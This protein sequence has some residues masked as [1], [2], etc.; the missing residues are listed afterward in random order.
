MAHYALID[1]GNIVT[2]V[3]VGQHESKDYDWEDHYTK[4]YGVT[5]K[6]TSY[7]M[8]GGIHKRDITPFRKN[9]AGIGFIYD[10]VRDAF[11]APKPYE[12]MLLNNTTCLWDY[13]VAKPTDGKFYNWNED[14]ESWEEDT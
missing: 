12:S 11:I 8:A 1:K 6:R 2:Q 14:T 10:D 13:S 7:N 5:C 9:Y 3:I 4:K